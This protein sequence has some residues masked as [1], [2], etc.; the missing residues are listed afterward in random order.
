MGTVFPKLFLR[1]HFLK[2]TRTAK[3]APNVNSLLAVKV[4]SAS[5]AALFFAVGMTVDSTLRILFYQYNPQS[6]QS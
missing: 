3:E 2:S 1:E 6:C 5:K 4:Q